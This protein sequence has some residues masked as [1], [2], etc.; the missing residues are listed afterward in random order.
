MA[1]TKLSLEV[2]KNIRDEWDPKQ[3]SLRQGIKASTGVDWQ[4]E[5]DWN[6]VYSSINEKNNFKNRPGNAAF[7]TIQG[8]IKN[9]TKQLEDT[10]VKDAFLQAVPKKTIVYAVQPKLTQGGYCDILFLDGMLALHSKSDAMCTNI[11]DI[12]QNLINLIPSPEKLTW[13]QKKNI[14]DEWEKKREN[15]EK[16]LKAATDCDWKFELN[17]ENILELV[18]DNNTYKKRP[19]YFVFESIN[20]LSNHISKKCKDSMVKEALLDAVTKRTIT[21]K[22]LPQNEV[23]GSL[24]DV[25]IEDGMIAICVKPDRICTNV[26]EIGQNLEKLL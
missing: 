19:G 7:N 21:Y 24:F 18:P 15:I 22:V 26:G 25:K 9:T 12:G 14:R 10:L 8:F 6:A 23:K 20:G 3:E 13:V 11:N 4:I 1:E 17:W 2:R 16:I 5:I